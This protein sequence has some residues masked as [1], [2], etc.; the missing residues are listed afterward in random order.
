MYTRSNKSLR[1]KKSALSLPGM[2]LRNRKSCLPTGPLLQFTTVTIGGK[3]LEFF[4]G[5]VFGVITGIW[6]IIK[7]DPLDNDDEDDDN[8]DE[9]Y[10][11]R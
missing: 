7:Y 8:N 3:M 2:K 5:F 9:G 11:Y 6:W 1:L 4:G 10:N